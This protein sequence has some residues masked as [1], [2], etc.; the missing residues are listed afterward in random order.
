MQVN[1]RLPQFIVACMGVLALCGLVAAAASARPTAQT[2][3]GDLLDPRTYAPESQL[4]LVVH[5]IGV[6]KYTCQADGTWL[7]TDPEAT[8]YKTTGVP[9]PIGT[10]FLNFATGLPVWQLKDESSVEAART[11]TASGGT[12]NIA[13]LLLQAVTTTAGSDGDRLTSTTWV[14]RLN[15]SGGVAPAETCVPGDRIAVPYSADYFFWRAAGGDESA[16]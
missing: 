3:P 4:F 1:C 11:Q 16:D 5:A 10:H 12:G 13:W 9:K 7:F 2:A 15:T 8:L 14:Q 6:Q